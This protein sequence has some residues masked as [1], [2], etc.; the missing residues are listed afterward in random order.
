MWVVVG[1]ASSLRVDCQS[2]SHPTWRLLR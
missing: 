1:T 2:H